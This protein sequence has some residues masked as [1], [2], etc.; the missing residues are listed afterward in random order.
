MISTLGPFLENLL[1]DGETKNATVLLFSLACLEPFIFTLN[2]AYKMNS[3]FLN[4]SL[5]LWT[6]S[7]AD[8]YTNTF[9]ILLGNL[10]NQVH[11]S[12]RK[13]SIFWVTTGESIASCFMIIIYYPSPFQLPI[14]I[15]LPFFWFPEQ[16]SHCSFRLC[17]ILRSQNHM[18][19]WFSLFFF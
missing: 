14:V 3:V 4:S 2:S 13:L 1:S 15:S 6:S 11:K 5:S 17:P 8:K 18:A 7:C 16:S 19:I 10:L 9:I 12:T